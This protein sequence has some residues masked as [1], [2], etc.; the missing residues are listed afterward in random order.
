VTNGAAADASALVNGFFQ[1]LEGFDLLLYRAVKEGTP[2]DGPEAER[3]LQEAAA[4]LAALIATVPEDVLARS[5]AV[6]EKVRGPAGGAGAG[7]AAAP[8][9]GDGAG[10]EDAAAAKEA[11][12]AEAT[13]EKARRTREDLDLLTELFQFD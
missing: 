2:V 7:G 3:R 6:L 5:R 1:K 10:A 12:R 4:G 13:A 9:G 11:A 8:A